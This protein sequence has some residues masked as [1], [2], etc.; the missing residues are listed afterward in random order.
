MEIISVREAARRLGLSKDSLH[1]LIKSG[2]LTAWR[3]TD[4]PRSALQ[5]DAESVAA[6]DARRRGTTNLPA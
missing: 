1:R 2:Q 3:K 5:I 4:A 6:Y